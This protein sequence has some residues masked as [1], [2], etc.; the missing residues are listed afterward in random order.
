VGH[1]PRH[2]LGLL[3]GGGAIAWAA[4]L[5]SWNTGDTLQ[6]AD[7]NANFALLQSQITTM[8][9][10][11]L[12]PRLPSAFRA[13]LAAATS[14]PT[15]GTVIP[16]DSV[17]YDLGGEYNAVTGA[18][19][20]KSAGVYTISCADW[21]TPAGTAAVYS[22]ALKKNGG[23]IA[24]NEIQSSTATGDAGSITPV[25][26]ATVLLAAGDTVQCAASQYTGTAQPLD[27]SGTWRNTVTAARLY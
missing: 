20:P 11:G 21:F 2:S 7:L 27:T 9:D 13:G 12:A 10:A 25:V 24:A 3:L 22:A 5:H 4:G 15:Q 6:A 23:I 8:G 1:S 17:E 16:F 19:T 18:F 26:T 14:V